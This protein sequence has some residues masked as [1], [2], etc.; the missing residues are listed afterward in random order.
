MIKEEES[1]A[2]KPLQGLIYPYPHKMLLMTTRAETKFLAGKRFY[3]D[4]EL[5]IEE[6]MQT[7]LANALEDAG[8]TIVKEYEPEQVD[9]V[10]TKYRSTKAYIRAC[11]D[12]KTV[13]TVWWVTNTLA[14]QRFESPMRTLLDYP[15]PSGGI[16][17]MENLVWRANAG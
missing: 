1:E 16:P 2:N 10:V 4:P 12:S 13:G 8:A 6:E 3:F 9:V 7:D 17:G 15:V 11:Q 14:R 5:G